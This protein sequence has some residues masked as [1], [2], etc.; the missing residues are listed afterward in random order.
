MAK[1]IL[2]ALDAVEIWVSVPYRF[3]V[4]NRN[5]PTQQ[6]ARIVEKKWKKKLPLCLFDVRQLL[7]YKSVEDV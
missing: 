7:N 2:L 6:L 1:N 4:W 5:W 3:Y